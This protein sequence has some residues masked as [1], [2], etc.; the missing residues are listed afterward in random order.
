MCMCVKNAE[1][2]KV[3]VLSFKCFYDVVAHV[4]VGVWVFWKRATT[5]KLHYLEYCIITVGYW[6]LV[7]MDMCRVCVGKVCVLHVAIKS[8]IKSCCLRHI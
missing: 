7:G 5:F 1:A 4:C 6:F 8:L 2:H 3:W